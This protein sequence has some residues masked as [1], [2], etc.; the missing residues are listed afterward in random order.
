[1]GNMQGTEEHDDMVRATA[2]AMGERDEKE[3]QG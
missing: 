3:G 1:M 2:S